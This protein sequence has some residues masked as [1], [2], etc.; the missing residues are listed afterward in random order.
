MPSMRRNSSIRVISLAVVVT[1]AALIPPLAFALSTTNS[2]GADLVLADM[3]LSRGDCRGATTR[4]IKAAQ[5]SADASIAK[6]ANQV[7]SD[8][9][10]VDASARAARRWQKLEPDNADA[11]A[12]VALA[13]VRL[14]QPAE[15]SAAILRTHALGGDE[16]L[17]KL[18]GEASD[19]GGTAIALQTLRP[20]FA[21]A[22]VSDRLL[23]AGV[24]LALE[25]FDFAT[26]RKLAERALDNEPASGVARAQLRA[27]SPPKATP[28][29]RS[30]F[31]RKP[32]R[33]TGDRTFRVRDTLL[34]LDRMDRLARNWKTCAPS[35]GARRGR[36]SPGQT[37]VSDG[38]LHR[39]RP[40]L[41]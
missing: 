39:S 19:S 17:I 24:D 6:R 11:A 22:Q 30:R 31:R 41:R 32:R 37:R 16:S 18:I 25:T 13:A 21:S 23:S 38:R 14:Y 8:C 33:W 1:T 40:P 28:S 3:A 20:M 26:A 36:P 5:A 7:A 35:I 12:A 10:Q 29:P 27:C 9:Q 4:Y 34:R 2:D 15:A